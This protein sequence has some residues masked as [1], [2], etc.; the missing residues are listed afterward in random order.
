MA[1]NSEPKRS[2]AHLGPI[3]PRDLDFAREKNGCGHCQKKCQKK[4]V[5]SSEKFCRIRANSC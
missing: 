5:K 2:S 1:S 3:P 4:I